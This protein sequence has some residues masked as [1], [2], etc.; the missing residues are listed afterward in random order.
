MRIQNISSKNKNA[1]KPGEQ[2][3]KIVI[4]S[5]KSLIK[6]DSVII[7]PEKKYLHKRPNNLN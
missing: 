4:S 3:I 7:Q 2:C 5:W 6:T 1:T